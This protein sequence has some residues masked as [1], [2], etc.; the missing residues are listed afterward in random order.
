MLAKP[1][2]LRVQRSAIV[3]SK[4]AL[5]DLVTLPGQKPVIS[6]GPPGYSA[7]SGHVVTVFGCTGFLGRY[8]VSKLGAPKSTTTSPNS[9]NSLTPSLL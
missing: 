2:L 4:R 9:S 7:V 5:H 1:Q 6:Y 3:Q 8:L